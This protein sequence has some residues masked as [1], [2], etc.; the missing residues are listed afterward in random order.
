MKALKFSGIAILLVAATAYAMDGVVLKFVAKK[1][2]VQ[3]VRV[4]GKID[5]QGIEATVDMVNQSKV[6]E[7]AEDGTISTEEKMVEGKY[8]VNGAET[9]MDPSKAMTMITKATGELKEIKGDD[10]VEGMYRAHNLMGFIPPTEAVQVGSKWKKE[11]AANKDTKAP[12]FKTECTILGEEK[13]DGTDTFKIQFKN[14][15]TEG[16]DPASIEGTIW[17]EKANCSLVKATQKWVAVT[18]PPSPFPITGSFT[19]ERVK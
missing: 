15:E 9:E 3:K 7:V 10:V 6:L 16:S 11:Y 8:S 18:M 19:M 12:A 5:I 4:K 14:S 1:D 17:I 13:I 2:E